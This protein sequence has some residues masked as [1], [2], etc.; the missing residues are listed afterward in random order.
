MF[1]LSCSNSSF[2]DIKGFVGEDTRL[3]SLCDFCFVLMEVFTM[4]D[5]LGKVRR[6]P[7]DGVGVALVGVS[8][9]FCCWTSSANTTFLGPTLLVVEVPLSANLPVVRPR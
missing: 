5:I 4:S 9:D 7:L 6:V 1:Y 8:V 3:V 2:E